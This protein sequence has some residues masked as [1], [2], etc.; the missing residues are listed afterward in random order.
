MKGLE[1]KNY[2]IALIEKPQKHQHYYQEK[3]INVN[4]LQVNK[5]YRLV[6]VR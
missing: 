6:Q 1:M 4:T 2:N 3:L 5:Y